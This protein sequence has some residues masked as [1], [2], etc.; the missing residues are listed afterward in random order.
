MPLLAKRLAEAGLLHA[1][2]D[3][4]HRPDDRRGGRRRRRRPRARRSCA[5]STTRS[6]RP[7]ASRSCT[8]TSPPRAAWSRS[9]ATSARS[10]TGPGPRLRVRGGLLRRGQGRADQAGRRRRDPQRGPLRRPRHARDAPGHRGA[11]RRGPRRRGRAAHRRPLLRRH[12]RP[13]GRPRRP[14]GGQGRPD[15]RGPRRRHDHRS[16]STPARSTSTSPTRRSPSASRAYESPRA[17]SSSTGVMAKYA[18]PSVSAAPSPGAV[19]ASRRPG[20]RAS[21]QPSLATRPPAA[22]AGY[23]ARNSSSSRLKRT[24]RSSCGTWPVSSKIS[25]RAFGDPPLV[26]RRR[27][28]PGRRGRCGPRRSGSG[29]RSR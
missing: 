4:R 16:T 15:R 20:T 2:R 28:G 27:R 25:S 17:A 5:R 14:R 18:A 13:D 11:R 23:S 29:P 9:P 1:R 12:P 7:A 22:A 21:E 24:G 19:T 26:A 8:A 10:H 6:R 3:H